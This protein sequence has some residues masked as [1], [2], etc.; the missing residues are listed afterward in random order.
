MR[1]DSIQIILFTLLAGI[2]I[3]RL[4]SV[5]GRQN[6]SDKSS[7]EDIRASS[8]R[9]S[10]RPDSNQDHSVDLDP[11]VRSQVLQIRKFDPGFSLHSFLK[12][13]EKAFS[14]IVIAYASNDLRVLKDLLSQQLHEEFKEAILERQALGEALETR[15]ISIDLPLVINIELNKTVTKIRLKFT[16]E[17]RHIRRNQAGEI[18]EG[19]LN[20]IERITDLWTFERDFSSLDPRWILVKVEN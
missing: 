12:G 5:L 4:Y 13:A 7:Q 1:A 8:T 17:Q 3:Y 6:E 14:S 11:R 16:S 10:Q 20:Q 18:V 19:G 15:I 9:G 2:L